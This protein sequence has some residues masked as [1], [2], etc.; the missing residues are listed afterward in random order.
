ME[1]AT[2]KSE[3]TSKF[4]DGFGKKRVFCRN[5]WVSFPESENRRTVYTNFGAV[6]RTDSY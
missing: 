4:M 1:C 3:R 6:R 2:C 5:C